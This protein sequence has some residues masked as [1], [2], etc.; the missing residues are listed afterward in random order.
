[1]GA[2]ARRKI[3]KIV[4]MQPNYAIL[5]KRTW[6]LA[7]YN[8]AVLNACLKEK[9]ET[10]LFDPN[11]TLMSEE[12]I[13]AKLRTMN[14]DVVGITSFSTEYL[15]EIYYYTKL[16]KEELPETIVMVGGVVPM[17]MID[18]V[19]QDPNVDFFVTGEGEYR[20]PAILEAL[21]SGGDITGF[22]GVAF[23]TE[24]RSFIKP[25]DYFIQDLD[26]VP[27]PDYGNLD[28]IDYGSQ[29]VK[30]ANGMTPR[31]YP[32][33]YT[34]TSRG[35]P[36]RCIFCAGRTISGRKVR[37]R[38]AENVLAEIDQL[39][40]EYG[41]REII[42]LD[43]HFLHNK[44]RAIDIMR[45]IEERAH[46]LVW[47]CGNVAV[48]S[49]TPEILEIKRRSGCYQLTFSI[50]SGVQET[51]SD[52]IKKPVNLEKAEEM[53]SIA[54]SLGFETISNFVIGFPGET[55]DQIRRSIDFAE[56]LD[57]DLVNFHIATPL[58][59]TELMDICIE[60]GLVEPDDTLYGYTKGVISTEDFTA[61]ELQILRSFEWDRINFGTEEK[62]NRVATIQGIR[63]EDV[64]EWRVRTRRSVGRTDNWK[65]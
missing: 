56:K 20:L 23:Q 65:E 57:I 49:L 30:Y 53:V 61:N 64:A 13:R 48:F 34:M 59:K 26:A 12:E 35:C 15:E 44:G 1:M 43:D 52:I 33:V 63:P 19:I 51:L 46:D 32:F 7:P 27:F 60:R 24:G 42:F 50:E 62:A 16:I 6:K 11:Y 2:S 4:L 22:D 36:Y 39:C 18:R 5:G 21:N 17:V 25:A 37:M 28:I 58:P 8:L 40:G 14:P 29:D 9:Y 38:S 54:K 47:K 10:I 31:Q 55:W 3:S 45:G 41:F